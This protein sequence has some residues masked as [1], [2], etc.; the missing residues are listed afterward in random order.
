MPG[1]PDQTS[2]S[3][4][5]TDSCRGC[6]GELCA[7]TPDAVRRRAPRSR[8]ASSPRSAPQCKIRG[9]GREKLDNE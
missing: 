4:G 8:A 6:A 5:S 2:A 7:T 9:T 3:V 1:V